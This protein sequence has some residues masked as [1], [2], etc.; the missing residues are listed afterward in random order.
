MRQLA[1]SACLLTPLLLSGCGFLGFINDTHNP[2][3]H[4]NQ[5]LGNSENMREIQGRPV[6]APVLLPEPGNVWPG[7]PPPVPSLEDLARQPETPVPALGPNTPAPVRSSLP[8]LIVP[9]VPPHLQPRPNT[10]FLNGPLSP[11]TGVVPPSQPVPPPP[12]ANAKGNVVIPNG[13]GTS[14]VIAPDGTITTIP[15]PPAAPQPQP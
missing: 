11:T 4:M 8:G 14:T 6:A 2:E 9:P 3:P 10:N 1:T 13:N 15:T 12:N 7:P 5:P